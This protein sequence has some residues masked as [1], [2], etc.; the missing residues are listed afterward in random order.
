MDPGLA[1]PGIRVG[2]RCKGSS[3]LC[4]A[5]TPRAYKG[6]AGEKTNNK[7]LRYYPAMAAPEDSLLSPITAT[8]DRSESTTILVAKV[9]DSVKTIYTT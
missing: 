4:R 6:A 1:V 7:Y 2:H 9:S 3:A 8:A 5:A